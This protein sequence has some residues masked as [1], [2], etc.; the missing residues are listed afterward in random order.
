[1]KFGVRNAR[2][3]PDWTIIRDL[4]GRFY[5]FTPFPPE[6][7]TNLSIHVHVR[8]PSTDDREQWLSRFAYSP[9]IARAAALGYVRI[10]EWEKDIRVL[11]EQ[12]NAFP[13]GVFVAWDTQFTAAEVTEPFLSRIPEMMENSANLFDIGFEPL[14]ERL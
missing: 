10:V 2:T 9:L 6:T 8:F 12:S 13:A 7:L 5:G 4:L 14:R 11:I 1:V 3:A